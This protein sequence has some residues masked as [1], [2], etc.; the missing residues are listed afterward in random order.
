MK[1]LWISSDHHLQHKNILKYQPDT[2]PF[3]N[4]EEHDE[5]I[6]QRHNSLVK[7]KDDVYFLGDFAF[8]SDIS[9]IAKCLKRMNGNKFFIFGNHDKIMH[10]EDIKKQFIW[11]KQ[12]Y[13][14]RIHGKKIAPI[15]LF[16]Y[17]IYSWNRQNYG[18]LHFYGHTHGAIP[19]LPGGKARDV[20]VDT[21]NCYPLN[22]QTL[23][24][25]MSK[26]ETVDTRAR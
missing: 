7:P 26:K 11:M 2:R 20:G 1:E 14:L 21:N 19:E 17:P 5:E 24:E 18:A 3:Q 16:H 23:I 9:Y 8:T 4:L 12:Y 10:S 6:I 22:V 25:E 15:V 13:E